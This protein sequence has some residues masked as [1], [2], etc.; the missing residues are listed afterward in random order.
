MV[1]GNAVGM[2]FKRKVAISAHGRKGMLVI[3]YVSQ[4][5]FFLYRKNTIGTGGGTQHEKAS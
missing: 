3:K 2:G 4:A 1:R 5:C